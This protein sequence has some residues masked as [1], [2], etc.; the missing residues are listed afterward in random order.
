MQM[1][2]LDTNVLLAWLLDG[3]SGRIPGKAPFRISLVVLAELVCTLRTT[4]KRT[5]ADIAKVVAEVLDL[6]DFCFADREVIANALLEYLD[7]SADF[8]DYLLLFDNQANGC[9]ATLTYD[10]KAGKHSGFTLIAK[11]Q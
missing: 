5:R 4:F 7:G 11:R 2:G 9:T 10:R 1:T 3:Q 6:P 8:T